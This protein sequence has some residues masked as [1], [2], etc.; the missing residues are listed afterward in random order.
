MYKIF[1]NANSVLLHSIC[2]LALIIYITKYKGHV[3]VIVMTKTA[4]TDTSHQI[5]ETLLN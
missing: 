5:F 3:N 4:H 2:A 1:T